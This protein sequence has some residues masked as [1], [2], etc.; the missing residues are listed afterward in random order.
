MGFKIRSLRRL[1]PT[2]ESVDGWLA[3][4]IDKRRFASD[5]VWTCRVDG[6]RDY[7]LSPEFTGTPKSAPGDSRITLHRSF[8]RSGDPFQSLGL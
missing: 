8:K 5:R 2:S 3:D 1:S 7:F 4:R 6:R